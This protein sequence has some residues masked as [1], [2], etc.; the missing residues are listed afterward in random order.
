[1]KFLPRYD[2]KRFSMNKKSKIPIISSGAMADIAF[3]LLI[4]FLVTTTIET[5]KGIRRS[6]PPIEGVTAPMPPRNILSV[7]VNRAN[8]IM[9][10]N[11]AIALSEVKESC[12]Q[13]IAN[14]EKSGDAPLRPNLAIISLQNDVGTSYETY[15]AVQNEVAAAYRELRNEYSHQVFKKPVDLL[16]KKQLD[17]VKQE[18]P[19]RI[20]E[21]NPKAD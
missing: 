8:Q 6:L 14:K 15:I 21:A 20:S 3:L 7:K 1:M 13:F 2:G 5:D 9:L 4:F 16:S 18:Y 19:M 11:Q 10:R 12:K 17:R